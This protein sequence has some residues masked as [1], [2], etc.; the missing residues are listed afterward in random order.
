MCTVAEFARI[1]A[2]GVSGR[3]VLPSDHQTAGFC[4]AGLGETEALKGQSPH[5]RGCEGTTLAPEL[6]VT[7]NTRRGREAAALPPNR[8]AVA[9]ADGR[10]LRPTRSVG[11]DRREAQPLLDF[12]SASEH[13]T[14]NT[15]HP[16]AGK[17][18]EPAPC[19]QTLQEFRE[20]EPIMSDLPHPLYDL[21]AHTCV[22]GCSDEDWTVDRALA[23]AEE[24]GLDGLAITDHLMP[25]TDFQTLLDNN[26]R[27][28]DLAS[29]REFQAW[30]SSEVEVFNDRGDL[31]IDDAQADELDFVMA[32]WGHVH[33]KHVEVPGE[34][35]L[36]ALFDFL[37]KVGLALCEDSRVA[38]IAHPWQTPSRWSEKWGFPAYGAD[39]IPDDLLSEL[40]QAAARTGTTLELNL[41]YVAKPDRPE[42]SE[43][44]QKQQKLL[45]VCRPLGCT[46]SLG[47][48]SHRGSAMPRVPQFVP[49]LPAMDLDV[50]E[51]W[52]P[53]A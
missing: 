1:R 12:H 48:D 53:V 2:I 39:D 20:P 27:L 19:G 31:N 43:L 18:V 47:G 46:F 50:A 28:L 29:E 44:F 30:S 32:A 9:E 4:P 16:S 37:H 38:V 23:R 42:A 6:A 26:R 5:T 35:T 45:R 21:H 34:R 24:L 52:V 49:F 14:P 11:L 13:L 41:A 36:A 40:G 51:L 7:S 8:V 17:A 25:T 22:S 33:L 15:D 10:A 3:R